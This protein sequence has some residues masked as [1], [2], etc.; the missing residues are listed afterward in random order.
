MG[1]KASHWWTVPQC[2]NCHANGVHMKGEI[3]FWGDIDRVKALALKLYEI[4]GNM[5]L[6]K[7]ITNGFRHQFLGGKFKR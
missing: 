3:S 7:R 5:E 2:H 4:S 6:A 1:T